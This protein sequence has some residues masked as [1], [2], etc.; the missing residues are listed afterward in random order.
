VKARALLGL[1]PAL[2]VI[3]M[4]VVGPYFA[5]YRIDESV[6]PPYAPPGEGALLGA[7]QLGRDVL[8]RLLAGGRELLATAALIA[9][10]VTG[11]AALLGAVAAL[12]PAAGRVIEWLADILIM[13]PA[14]LGILLIVLSWPT[15]AWLALV[16]AAVALGLPYAVRVV[17]AASTPVAA[18]GY[19]EVA[20]AQGER[21]WHLVSREVLPNLSA[22]LL[23]L[24][25]LRFIEAVYVVA[26]AGFLEI[27]PQPP[28][29]HWAL[30]VRENAPGIL[31]NPWAV[32]APSL[33][34]GALAISVTLAA[35][36]LAPSAARSLEPAR[37]ASRRASRR[38][39]EP[40]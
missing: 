3:A 15:Q 29:A 32:L 17:A 14:V 13:L 18:S 12:R 9:V 28:A 37:R 19:V 34:I 4:A 23:T 26:T 5:P 8:S 40:V 1:F 20:L 33:A 2:I 22:T 21:L 10:L 39:V 24:L 25:G 11:L 38:E 36:T 27:G 31:L 6:F 16:C 35:D 30:M 7:D